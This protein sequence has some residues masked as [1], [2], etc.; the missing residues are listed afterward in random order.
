MT[1]RQNFK[2]IVRESIHGTDTLTSLND[3]VLAL[4]I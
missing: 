4:I 2:E 1:N 3:S